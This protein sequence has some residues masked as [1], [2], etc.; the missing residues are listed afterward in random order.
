MKRNRAPKTIL[1]LMLAGILSLSLFG[2]IPT[3]NPTP[4]TEGTPP[5]QEAINQEDLAIQL[6]AKY[7]ID[8][9]NE[10]LPPIDPVP[11]D[12]TFTYQL[13]FDPNDYVDEYPSTY[14][15]VGVFADPELTQIVPMDWWAD[16]VTDNNWEIKISP[17][18]FPAAGIRNKYGDSSHERKISESLN[19]I[20]YVDFKGQYKD[21]GNLPRYYLAQFLDLDTGEKLTKPLVQ[22]FTVQAELPAPATTVFV[23]EHGMLSLKWKPV[24]GA[25]RYLIFSYYSTDD[26]R[27]ASYWPGTNL[28]VVDGTKTEWHAANNRDFMSINIIDPRIYPEKAAQGIETEPRSYY[29]ERIGVIALGPEGHSSLDN[30]HK[31]GDFDN[32]LVYQLARDAWDEDRYTVSGHLALFL[33]SMDDMPSQIPVQMCDASIVYKTVDYDF[34]NAE[35]LEERFITENSWDEDGNPTSLEKVRVMKVNFRLPQSGITGICR[36][37]EPPSTW[38]RDLE[39]IKKRQEALLRAAMS[40]QTQETIQQRV[41]MRAEGQERPTSRE[42][43]PLDIEVFATNPLSEYLAI[44]LLAG[45]EKIPLDSFPKASDTNHLTDALFEAIYQNP[46][47]LGISEMYLDRYYNLIIEY[48]D[49]PAVR[50]EKQ[51]AIQD[52]IQQVIPQIITSNM[53]PLEREIA[54]NDYLCDTIEYDMALL[55]DAQKTNY[56]YVDPKYNDSFTAYGALIEGLCVC[57]GYAAAFKL[58]ADAAGLESIV[59]TG[60]LEGSIGHAW[61]RVL[62]NGEWKNIDVTNNDNPLLFNV[63][64]NLPDDIVAGILVEDKEYLL[65]SELYRFYSN[66]DSAEYY[67]IKGAFYS[68]TQIVD[69]LA[70]GLQQDGSV[71]LR[72]DYS[73]SEGEYR[74]IV[75]DVQVKLGGVDLYGCHLLGLI[76]LSSEAL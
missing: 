54:I 8:D 53:S 3:Q 10:Y 41:D 15:W 74:A 67:R 39:Q 48:E 1:S 38:K 35:E 73:I 32:R 61:N 20:D 24:A 12:Q 18:E 49:A 19:D 6:L 68:R 11:R 9:K 31:L 55:E 60:T 64:L 13:N 72:T 4:K 58:L 22:V 14:D 2:C 33:Q 7:G 50:V 57:A 42:I 43:T 69:E 51:Q 30:L 40:Q 36:V 75:R 28:D 46:L 56:T 23:D 47:I 25:E 52:K 29:C 65:D 5:S 45:A 62:I 70:A 26:T 44:N 71:V 17:Y 34:E 21:W 16:K 76:Y 27:Y 63:L 37:E 59:V 66:D